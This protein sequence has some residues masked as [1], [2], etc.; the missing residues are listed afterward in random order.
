VTTADDV[1]VSCNFLGTDATGTQDLGNGVDGIRVDGSSNALV[2]STDPS[3]RN[4]LSG[5]A[6]GVSIVNAGSD[7]S[8]VV[9]N[10]IGTDV[11]GMFAI[12]NDVTGVLVQ[13]ASDV[14]VG[15]VAPD[16][17]NLIS[18]NSAGVLVLMAAAN[19]LVLGNS[20]GLDATGEP[21]L[22]NGTGIAVNN[23][24]QDTVI[25]SLEL[26]G[27]GNVIAG[28]GFGVLFF[29]GATTFGTTI[30]GNAIYE[31]DALGIA[32]LDTEYAPTPNDD[33]DADT[34]PNL[35][36]NYPDLANAAWDGA[37]HELAVASFVTTDPANA[38]YPLRIDYYRADADGQEGEA[39]L[40]A[41]LFTAAD[42]ANGEPVTATFVPDS[43]VGPGDVVVTTAT[44]AGGNTSEFSAGVVVPEAAS[45][46][47]GVLAWAA[48]GALARARPR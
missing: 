46:L 30:R 18:G 23:G 44:D 36:Q 7:G 6:R 48:L 37:A 14:T 19:V 5:N 3:G 38:A 15:G 9:G 45:L 1:V 34:G 35:L 32:F 25:G 8:E 33:G 39:W 28:N 12:P 20:I 4:L 26:E 24:P 10:Y 2:G 42:Y 16:A 21:V 29:T 47:Q 27:L 11:T 13:S 40:G 22:G 17:T 43:A 41:S 31:N